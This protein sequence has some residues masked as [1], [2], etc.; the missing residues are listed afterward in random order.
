MLRAVGLVSKDVAQATLAVRTQSESATKAA[1]REQAEVETAATELA[2]AAE[3]LSSVARQ[4]LQAN[5]VQRTFLGG[6]V[7]VFTGFEDGDLEKIKSYLL[8]I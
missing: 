7:P 2:T 8:K 4:A 5:E 6:Q 3:S 1:V